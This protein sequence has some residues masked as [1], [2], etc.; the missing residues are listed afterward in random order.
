MLA[1]NCLSLSILLTKPISHSY[2]QLA[3]ADKR[4]KS[5]RAS[6]SKDIVMNRRK[7]VCQQITCLLAIKSAL[8]ADDIFDVIMWLVD[9][10]LK[11]HF[12]GRKWS[13]SENIA[14]ERLFL[15]LRNFLAIGASPLSS[16]Q[17]AFDAQ[18]IHN[19]FILMLQKGFINILATTTASLGQERYAQWV[20]LHVHI[21]FHLLRGR[22]AK[23]LLSIW[24]SSKL[25]TIT[26]TEELLSEKQDRPKTSSTS[27][28]QTHQHHPQSQTVSSSF[29]KKPS[30]GLLQTLKTEKSN[31]DARV[32]KFSRFGAIYKVQATMKKSAVGPEGIDSA[33]EGAIGEPIV[34][35]V[36]NPLVSFAESLPQ[37]KRKRQK[38]NLTFAADED[39]SNAVSGAGSLLDPYDTLAGIVVASFVEHLVKHG[40]QEF[41]FSVKSVWRRD[42]P[43]MG[44]EDDLVYYQM[45]SVFVKYRR[46]QLLM[47]HSKHLAETPSTGW[48]P[49]LRVPLQILDRM[50]INRAYSNIESLKVAKQFDKIVHPMELF[51]EVVASI[52]L[53]LLSSKQMDHD[54][55]IGVLNRIFYASAQNERI[56]PLPNLLRDWR[57]GTYGKKHLFTLVEMVHEAMKT[58]EEARLLFSSDYGVNA[59]RQVDS[60]SM[61]QYIAAALKFDPDE[62]FRKLLSSGTVSLYT[63]VLENYATNPPHVNHY[64]TLFLQRMCM[65][66]I[67]IGI[68]LP[69]QGD[70]QRDLTLAHMLFN[71]QTIVVFEKILNDTDRRVMK[72]LEP[73][74]RLI[75][76]LVRTLGE[77]SSKNHLIF[78]EMLLQHPHAQHFCETMDSVYDAHLYT[79]QP[80]KSKSSGFYDS[81]DDN[82]DAGSIR[83]EEELS[84]QARTE[85]SVDFEDEHEYDEFEELPS[86]SRVVAEKKHKKKKQKVKEIQ[87]TK[88]N[89]DGETNSDWDSD[90]EKRKIAKKKKP[91]KW[92]S[93]EDE[94][95]REQYE[96]YAGSRG[97]F[98]ILAQNDFLRYIWILSIFTS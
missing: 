87:N 45:A 42:L 63:R 30:T 95:L 96:I 61:Q 21:I 43:Q 48:K 31:R 81:D 47:E 17:E 98:D 93:T 50:T 25:L 14:M 79:M 40:F 75:K 34:H 23:T 92:T 73:L 80:G 54:I 89:S 58:L 91:L 37:A 3:V 39:I 70:S 32:S 24:K 67:E 57:P 33:V 9:K 83:S 60:I 6:E 49:D 11:A 19:R 82:S 4:K 36:H 59:T 52:R 16:P 12:L 94:E 22:D 65:Q 51:K 5:E 72:Q 8:L 76:N 62:Y 84:R 86:V 15:F 10:P 44:P 1:R 46:M 7:N 78:V 41:A 29:V 88:Y 38:N 55:A 90:E 56:D 69:D 53:F 13:D 97:V 66:K 2:L 64:V 85:P 77:L 20:K 27:I 35:I 71:I 28:L 18:C 74:V 26:K 68:K